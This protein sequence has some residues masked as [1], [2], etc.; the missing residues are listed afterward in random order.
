MSVLHLKNLIVLKFYLRNFCS[1]KFLIFQESAWPSGRLLGGS[2]LLNALHYLRG[3]V[4]GFDE[5]AEK[6]G[7]K[8]WKLSNI[9]KYYTALEDYNGWF[10]KGAQKYATLMCPF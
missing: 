7:D 10:P 4:Q 5:V 1:Y 6:T 3:N 9:L 8:R 2:S